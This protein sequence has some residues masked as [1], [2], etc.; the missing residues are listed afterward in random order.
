M[1]DLNAAQ[2]S[3]GEALDAARAGEDKALAQQVRDL[4]AQ[5]VRLLTGLWRLMR[6]HEPDNDAF[7]NPTRDFALTLV[8]LIELLGPLHLVCVEG[9]VYINDVRIRIDDRTGG[10]ANLEEEL[11]AHHSGGLEFAQPLDDRSIRSLLHVLAGRPAEQHPLRALATRIREAELTTVTVNGLFRLRVSGEQTGPTPTR[12][13]VVQTA[14]RATGLV[15]E[16]WDNL[17]AGRTPNPLPVRRLVNDLVDSVARGEHILPDA[18]AG[19]GSAVAGHSLRVCSLSILIGAELGLPPA[20]LADLG[21]AAM[22]HDAG[23]GARE[24]GYAPPFERHAGAGACMLLRQR[25]FHPAKVK[26]LLV[27]FEHHDPMSRT[28]ILLARIVHIADDFDTLSRNRSGGAFYSPA[29]ALELM[30]G[31]AGTLYDPGLLQLLINRIGK[32]PPGTLLRLRDGRTVVSVSGS[33][34]QA[35]FARPLCRVVITADGTPVLPG[36]PEQVEVD[37]ALGGGV[38]EVIEPRGAPPP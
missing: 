37:L 27:A 17:A 5:A 11:R 10:A 2:K 28:P 21:V 30:S 36:S 1:S 23:Y 6:T 38:I 7:E 14:E 26:R 4:G 25:G 3:I 19:A 24:D 18:A 12:R 29:L 8:R 15:S 13:D 34:G 22:F 35:S 16:A 32:Y 31:A 9:Q 20:V 33:R